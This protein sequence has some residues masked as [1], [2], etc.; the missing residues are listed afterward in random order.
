MMTPE[1]RIDVASLR[2]AMADRDQEVGPKSRHADVDVER[3]FAIKVL[4]ASRVA[5]DR[6]GH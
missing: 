6:I 1:P 3:A 2:L 5:G 4:H